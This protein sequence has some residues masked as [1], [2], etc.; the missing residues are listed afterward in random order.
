MA[1]SPQVYLRCPFWHATALAGAT[2][3]ALCVSPR[4][5]RVSS[6]LYWQDHLKLWLNLTSN[7]SLVELPNYSTESELQYDDATEDAFDNEIKQRSQILTASM[8]YNKG[9]VGTIYSALY[10]TILIQIGLVMRYT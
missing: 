5:A 4:V 7:I 10:I 3:V 8:T 9:A 1:C 2:I 6:L